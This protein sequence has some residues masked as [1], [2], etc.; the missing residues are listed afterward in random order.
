MRRFQTISARY[1]K[2][3]CLLGQRLLPS[4]ESFQNKNLA[5]IEP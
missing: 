2:A 1:E 3:R 4:A 5:C